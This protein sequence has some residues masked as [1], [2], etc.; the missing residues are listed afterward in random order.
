MK[1]F[2]DVGGLF[3][4]YVMRTGPTGSSESPWREKATGCP[5]GWERAC[6]WIRCTMTQIG[7]EGSNWFTGCEI[8]PAPECPCINVSEGK[9]TCRSSAV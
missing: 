5:V 8:E 7:R 1:I 9:W 6:H 2:D 4:I 3:H